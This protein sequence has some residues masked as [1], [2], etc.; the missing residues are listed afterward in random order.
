MTIACPDGDGA[1]SEPA[2]DVLAIVNLSDYVPNEDECSVLQKGLGFCPTQVGN[3]VDVTVDLHKFIH[4]LKLKHYFHANPKC[5]MPTI[6]TCQT[7]N[8]TV[9]D[10]ENIQLLMSLSDSD[11]IPL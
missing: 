5:N 4:I 8:H 2:H 3:I 1:L 10:K 9:G 7:P 11:I 6:E